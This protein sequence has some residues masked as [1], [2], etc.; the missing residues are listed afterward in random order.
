LISVVDKSIYV[1]SFPLAVLML[2]NNAN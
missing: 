2:L 1:V